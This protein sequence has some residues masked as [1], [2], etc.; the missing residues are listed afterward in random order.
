MAV[1]SLAEVMSTATYH[2]PPATV[3]AVDTK[4]VVFKM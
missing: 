4:A 2:E 1:R 3:N